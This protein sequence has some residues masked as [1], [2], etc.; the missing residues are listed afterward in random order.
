MYIQPLIPFG[1]GL[2]ALF[3]HGSDFFRSAAMTL[4]HA[5]PSGKISEISAHLGPVSGME[6][7]DNMQHPPDIEE[8]FVQ[9]MVNHQAALNA[10]VLALMPGHPD[11]DDVVQEVN[12]LVWKKRGEFHIGTNFKDWVFSIAKF[13]VMALWR[14]QKRRKVWAIPDETL[15]KLMDDAVRLREDDQDL[16]QEAL[17]ECIQRLPSKERGLIL[18]RYMQ[19]N[20][21]QET[22]QMVGR[23]AENLKGTLHRIRLG[24]RA[25]VQGKINVWRATT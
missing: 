13:K 12:S 3:F 6:E 23:K 18:S 14:D 19:G 10:F 17:R 4:D 20:S 25:C 11:A 16:R 7:Q 2:V 5:L 1:H 15:T 22:A 8:T 21:L 24:L 9:L